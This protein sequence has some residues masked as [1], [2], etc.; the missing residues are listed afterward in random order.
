[1]HVTLS[2]WHES[3]VCT[4]CEKDRE[5]VATT[6]SDGFLKEAPLCWK[7][8]QT[9]Y[10]VRQRQQPAAPPPRDAR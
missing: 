2:S 1:M 10:K 3:A 8:L 6:F 9:A 7:C 5:C 4:W